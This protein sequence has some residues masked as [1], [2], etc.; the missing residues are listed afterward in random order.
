MFRRWKKAQSPERAAGMRAVTILVLGA[1]LSACG[2]AEAGSQAGA[3]AFQRVVN[4]EVL[5]IEARSFEETIRIAGTVQANVDVMISAEEPGVVRETFAERGAIV[6]SGDAILQVDDRILRSQVA[7]AEA[8][9]NLARETWERRRRLFEEDGV[10]SELA[11]L[12][13]RYQADQADAVLASLRER[14]DRTLILAPIAGVLEARP[15]E[16]GTMVGIGTPV[17]RIVQVDPIKVLAGV[18]ERFA[19]LVGPASRATVTFDALGPEVHE[20][21][22]RYIGATVNPS[23]R[24]FEV[25]LSI[26]NQERSIKPEMVAN[27]NVVLREREGAIV[28]PQESVVRVEEGFVAFVV[29]DEGEASIAEVRPIR[30]GATQR[31]EVVVEEGLAVGER[32][33]VLGQN[34]V[35]NGDHVQVVRTRETTVTGGGS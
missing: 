32:L 20:A 28:I 31:N 15:V 10:G 25:E 33:I 2:D 5:P 11:Y 4:V 17:A 27:V 13:A 18:P 22:V 30:L 29:R 19:G 8:R 12:E 21:R 7:E 16:V 35:A 24:T 9:A 23:N 3:D 34:Q 14:L 1:A 6:R 26:P